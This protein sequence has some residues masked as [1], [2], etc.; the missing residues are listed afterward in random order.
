MRRVSADDLRPAR[1]FDLRALLVSV[2]VG[3]GSTVALWAEARPAHQGATA[4]TFADASAFV[5][6]PLIVAPTV[7]LV[8]ARGG[9]FWTA[10]GAIPV[11]FLAALAIIGLL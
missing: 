5:F 1:D 9:R 8:A 6:G 4:A 7:A 11:A 3:A 10:L 2:V